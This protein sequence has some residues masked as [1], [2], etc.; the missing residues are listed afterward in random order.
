MPDA[1]PGA[2]SAMPPAT[3]PGRMNHGG[4]KA[5]SLERELPGVLFRPLASGPRPEALGRVFEGGDSV[6][7]G[8]VCRRGGFSNGLPVPFPIPRVAGLGKVRSGWWAMKDTS[9][10][11]TKENATDW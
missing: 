7:A 8:R 6:V 1:C 9:A 10:L 5:R 2:W 3:F 11:T 4:A